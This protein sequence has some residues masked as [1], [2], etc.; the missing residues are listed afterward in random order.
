MPKNDDCDENNVTPAS[1]ESFQNLLT[2]CF[3]RDSKNRPSTNV[4]QQHQFFCERD[5]NE[6]IIEDVSDAEYRCF[7]AEKN[8]RCSKLSTTPLSPISPISPLKL[9]QLK[10]Q[11]QTP[12]VPKVAGAIQSEDW[13]SWAKEAA[14]QKL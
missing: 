13:P 14:K 1:C 11:E 7:S 10:R 4:L 6:S 8:S 2:Q 12:P 3:Q 5:P 9:L